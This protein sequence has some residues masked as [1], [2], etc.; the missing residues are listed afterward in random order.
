M[1]WKGCGRRVMTCPIFRYHPGFYICL[2]ALWKITRTF[3]GDSSHSRCLQNVAPDDFLGRIINFWNLTQWSPSVHYQCFVG[4]CCMHFQSTGSRFFWNSTY[5]PDYYSVSNHR[6]MIITFTDART[7]HS[8]SA[9]SLAKDSMIPYLKAQLNIV[10]WYHI[11]L[12]KETNPFTKCSGFRKKT[13]H[14]EES[15]KE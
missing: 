13:I 4:S 12:K 5:P 15:P 7:S 8:Y 14:D 2:K 10:S 9:S 3:S 11:R 6:T 1:R